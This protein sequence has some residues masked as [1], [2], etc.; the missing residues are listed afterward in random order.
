MKL[1]GHD[2][3]EP[4]ALCHFFVGPPPAD[5]SA[6]GNPQGP[7]G[8]SAIR[9]K[10]EYP[11]AAPP[12]RKPG[13]SRAAVRTQAASWGAIRL[14]RRSSRVS[15][16]DR[17]DQ[18]PHAG[19]AFRPQVPE[20]R[21][22]HDRRHEAAPQAP[23]GRGR[24]ASPCGK[25]CRHGCRSAP[26]RS[27][28]PRFQE[29]LPQGIGVNPVMLLQRGRCGRTR[30][31]GTRRPG[32]IPRDL[33]KPK[34]AA[35]QRYLRVPHAP[36]SLERHVPLGVDFGAFAQ[37]LAPLGMVDVVVEERTGVCRGRSRALSS[38]PATTDACRSTGPNSS[39]SFALSGPLVRAEVLAAPG[40]QRR[41]RAPWKGAF[42][43]CNHPRAADHTKPFHESKIFSRRRS[44]LKNS[45]A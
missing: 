41:F 1:P 39:H 37:H 9:T 6:P 36:R 27:G 13:A 10:N 7:R 35:G 31:P 20:R 38:L 25:R 3:G 28:G 12:R 21:R 17:S 14:P 40:Q 18:R 11:F 24:S 43:L 16:P 8:R 22:H 4:F 34:A 15:Q 33:H 5:R 19:L 30:W 29:G 26:W 44:P 32:G 45:R 2:S 42:L 23:A